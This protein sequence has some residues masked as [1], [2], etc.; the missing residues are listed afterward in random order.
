MKYM[1]PDEAAE[2]LYEQIAN[3]QAQLQLV[4]GELKILFERLRTDEIFAKG[5]HC[6][7]QG[8]KYSTIFPEGAEGMEA[9]RKTRNWLD[10]KG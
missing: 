3:Q 2:E 8:T 5:F 9:G 4:K 6:G 7:Y 1:N 10:A